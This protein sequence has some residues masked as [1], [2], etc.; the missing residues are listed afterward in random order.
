[1][2]AQIPTEP[3]NS[4]DDLGVCYLITVVRAEVKGGEKRSKFVWHS[5]LLEERVDTTQ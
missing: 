2:Y 3:Q 1:M 4:L 5:R